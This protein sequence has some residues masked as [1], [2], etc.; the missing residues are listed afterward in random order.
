[1]AKLLAERLVVIDPGFGIETAA[2]TASWVEALTERQT[3]GRHVNDGVGDVD[4][5]QL[6]DT[7]G[8]RLGAS[9]V[10]RLSP[11]ESALPE[12]TVRRISPLR[13]AKGLGW[14]QHLPRLGVRTNSEPFASPSV[15][16]V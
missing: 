16:P 4:V 3:I 6:V 11:V 2:L 9:N 12:R 13:P 14:P 5:S 15:G 1:M 7:L 8:A 10:F